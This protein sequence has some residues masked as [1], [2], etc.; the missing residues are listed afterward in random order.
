M[1][2]ANIGISR[3]SWKM[4]NIPLNILK[5]IQEA[6]YTP[7]GSAVFK[8]YSKDLFDKS[9]K[10]GIL[11]QVPSGEHLFRLERDDNLQIHFF[12]S[13]PGTA[14]R[15]ATI[16]LKDVP[17]SEHIFMSF[18]W[19][20][21]EINFYIG[22]RTPGGKLFSAKGIP[23]QKQFR[24]GKDRRVYQI[25]GHG[26]DVTDISFYRDGKPVLQP[27]A[28]DA[29][30]ETVRATEILATGQSNL[31]YIF[32]LAMT[33]LTLAVLVTG[34]E[35]YTKKRFLE[36][37]QEG[38]M[39][40]IDAVVNAFFPRKERDA[41][42]SE[43]LKSEAKD[44]QETVLQSIVERGNINFQSYQKCKL[45]YNKAY[46]IKFGDLGLQ[47]AALI[48]IK[49]YILYRH[50]IIHVSALLGFLNQPEF[51][52]EEPV[53]PKK[54]LA[55]EAIKDFDNFI[56]RLHEATLKLKTLSKGLT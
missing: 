35:A 27:T 20:P 40:D 1:S 56:K 12:H 25:C 41:G 5:Q 2:K 46:Q 4:N 42:I 6:M 26:V 10:G 49:K 47:P 38:I 32:E 33:N 18:T 29:W 30:R 11:L 44:I 22:T 16:D 54:E 55:S 43:I 52:L 19:S 21:S 45:A 14:T 7:V 51:P 53:L 34:F 24:V 39:P 37:E 9:V 13:S 36:I 31:G 50:R 15:V 8:C 23:S 17:P 48:R 28:L 3:G